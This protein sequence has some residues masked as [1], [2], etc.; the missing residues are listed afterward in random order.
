MGSSGSEC[1]ASTVSSDEEWN[2][3]VRANNTV[4]S[5]NNKIY[6]SGSKKPLLPFVWENYAKTFICTDSGEHKPR[7]KGKRKRLQSRAM[8]CGAQ[9]NACV[10]VID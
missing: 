5:R 3:R 7:G 1:S 6:S 9:T 10:R 4:A 8:E 2:Y